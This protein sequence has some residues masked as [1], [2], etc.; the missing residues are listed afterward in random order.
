MTRFWIWT[1]G[2]AVAFVATVSSPAHAGF[3]IYT[4][5]ANFDAA[6]TTTTIDFEGVPTGS[7]VDY[8]TAA[9]YTAMGVNF[10]GIRD[11]P[12]NFYLFNVDPGQFAPFYDWGS[13]DVLA[14]PTGPAGGLSGRIEVTLGAGVTAIGVDLMT[15]LGSNGVAYLSGYGGIVDVKLSTGDTISLA[16]NPY[17]NRE[18]LGIISDV[19]ISSVSY[20]A[21]GEVYLN[22][23]NF[24]FGDTSPPVNPT[25]APAGVVLFGLG[26]AGLGMFR[27][28]RK[29]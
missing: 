16:T 29:G 7:N 13:G 12:G 10:K 6:S 3:V 8:S 9:G 4:S 21:R 23:D 14:G 15:F 5:R 25:P 28:F 26:F 2:A 24:S 1:F 17:P 19:S 22:I 18:F 27:S 11:N 20:R